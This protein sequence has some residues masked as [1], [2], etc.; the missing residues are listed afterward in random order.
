MK[1]FYSISTLYALKPTLILPLHIS[2]IFN[3]HKRY[4]NVPI[5]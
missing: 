1:K 2:K 5:L 4:P 3:S